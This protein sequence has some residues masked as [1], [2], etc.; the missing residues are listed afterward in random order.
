MYNDNFIIITENE[1]F[2]K[3]LKIILEK[4]GKL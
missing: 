4:Y 3:D 2:N 1:I